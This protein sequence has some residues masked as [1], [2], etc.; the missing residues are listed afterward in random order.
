MKPKHFLLTAICLLITANGLAQLRVRPHGATMLGNNT[1]EL[2]LIFPELRDTVTMLKIYGPGASNGEKGR[3]SFGDQLWNFAYNVMLGEA[4]QGNTDQLWLHGRNG[5]CATFNGGADTLL[6]YFPL[7]E[8]V[9]DISCPVRSNA[10]YLTSDERL[11]QDVEHID[12]ALSVV[13]A[14]NG[15]SYR[16]KSPEVDTR[17]DAML[18]QLAAIDTTGG[19]ARYKAESEQMRANRADHSTH[20]GFLA[21]EVEQVLPELVRT[22]KDGMKSVD[23]IAVIPLLVN[24]VQELR[25]ELAEVKGQQAPKAPAQTPQTSG[26]DDIADGLTVPALYQ[27][28][29]NPFTADTHIRYCLPESVVQADLYIYDMQGKQVKRITVTGRG[30]SAVTIHGSELQAGMYI[31]ALIADGQ[32]VDSKRMILTK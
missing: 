3:L 20:Y 29:P 25:T 24:A 19:A 18:D 31:Y 15:V 4:G 11:K 22:D 14:L 7:D 17:S 32:E 27:N 16:Y 12:D 2:N 21:Q 10:V 9:L 5:L 6:S 26:T 8:D 28:I 30:E 23:Y 1:S 13:S